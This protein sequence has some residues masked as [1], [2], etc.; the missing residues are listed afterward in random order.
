MLIYLNTSLVFC[1]K[2]NDFHNFSYVAS[3][4]KLFSGLLNLSNTFSFCSDIAFSFSHTVYMDISLLITERSIYALLFLW[5]KV[6][7]CVC[8][9]RVVF[10]DL[11]CLWITGNEEETEMEGKLR[12]GRRWDGNKRALGS[13]NNNLY[14]SKWSFIP[15]LLSQCQ[16]RSPWGAQQCVLITILM[17]AYWNHTKLKFFH[18]NLLPEKEMSADNGFFPPTSGKRALF[19][20]FSPIRAPHDIC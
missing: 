13:H 6:K 14:T 4:S 1:N 19:I 5:F 16:H 15:C 18:L 9:S 11:K 7:S 20:Y 2:S 10:R 8:G 3:V 17:H 12:K